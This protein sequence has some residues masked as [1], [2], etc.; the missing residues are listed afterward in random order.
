MD[1][2]P[3][4]ENEKEPRQLTGISLIASTPKESYNMAY[5]LRPPI[6]VNILQEGA[7]PTQVCSSG[8][9]LCEGS[10]GGWLGS[11]VTLDLVPY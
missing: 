5:N 8:D 11:G 1:V 10:L 6:P 3:P 9:N 4:P 7:P 2:N